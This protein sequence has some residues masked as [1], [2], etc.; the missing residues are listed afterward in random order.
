M[1]KRHN[2]NIKRTVERHNCCACVGVLREEKWYFLRG[3]VNKPLFKNHF[4]FKKKF[5][6]GGLKERIEWRE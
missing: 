1:M 6:F 3:F 5:G 2:T 4:L